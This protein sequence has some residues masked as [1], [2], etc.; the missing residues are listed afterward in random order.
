MRQQKPFPWQKSGRDDA[1]LCSDVQ[2]I[3]LLFFQRFI[4]HFPAYRIVCSLYS[5]E[6]EE[7]MHCSLEAGEGKDGD[8]FLPKKLPDPNNWGAAVCEMISLVSPFCPWTMT[9][10][11]LSMDTVY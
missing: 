9:F 8:H 7:Y 5:E 3:I 1:V 6:T 11:L 10:I 4:I 2:I